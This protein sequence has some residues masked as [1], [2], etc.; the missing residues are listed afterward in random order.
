M[1]PYCVQDAIPTKVSGAE[2]QRTSTETVTLPD[3]ESGSREFVLRTNRESVCTPVLT[4]VFVA[5]LT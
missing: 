1:L 2:D 3:G 5:T 4:G